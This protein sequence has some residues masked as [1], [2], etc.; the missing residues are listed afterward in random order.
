MLYLMCNKSLNLIK[1][2]LN[3]QY[4]ISIKLLMVNFPINHNPGNLLLSLFKARITVIEYIPGQA[5]PW[6]QYS[7]HIPQFIQL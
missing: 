1:Y 2:K 4:Q 3:I 7:L 6:E 5:H